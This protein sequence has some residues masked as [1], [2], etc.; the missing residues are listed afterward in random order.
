VV[1][2]QAATATESAVIN[3]DN[4]QDMGTWFKTLM[5]DTTA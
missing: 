1:N 4:F 2:G 3:S 5:Q